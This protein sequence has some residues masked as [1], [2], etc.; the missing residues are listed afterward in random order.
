VTPPSAHRQINAVRVAS[1]SWDPQRRLGLRVV[2]QVW[3]IGRSGYRAPAPV[4]AAAAAK[5]ESFTVRVLL[6]L[7]PAMRY[8]PAF[9]QKS[10]HLDLP[11]ARVSRSK[12]R[13][14][15]RRHRHIRTLPPPT[16]QR[17]PD[18]TAVAVLD[19]PSARTVVVE[20]V[21]AEWLSLHGPHYRRV[22]VGTARADTS[23]GVLQPARLRH[24]RRGA[25]RAR[26][27]VRLRQER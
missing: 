25:A 10:Q 13:L 24:H 2:T 16:A 26:R 23:P 21:L 1:A 18:P 4:T 19:M 9:T 12:V 11:S 8:P 3:N 6:A 14:T 7:A 22:E 15:A 20:A 27:L 5:P 17:Y